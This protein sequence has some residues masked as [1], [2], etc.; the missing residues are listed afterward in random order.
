[1]KRKVIIKNIILILLII[2]LILLITAFIIAPKIILKG[3]KKIHITYQ[4][5]YNDPGYIAKT[6]GQD[7]TTKVRI[8]GKV[9]TDKLGVYQISY[10]VKSNYITTVVKRKVVVIDDVKPI[11]K[12]VG[13]KKIKVCPGNKYKELGYSAIDNYDG[14]I[15]DKVQI[16][17]LEDEIIYTVIDSSFNKSVIKRKLIFI[18]DEAPVISLK[19]DNPYYLIKDRNYNEFGYNIS[20]NCA[21]EINSKVTIS[22]NINNNVVG[23]YNVIYSVQDDFGNE[24][25]AIR[26]VNVYALA[27]QTGSTIYLTF[28]DGPSSITPQVLNILK[29]EGVKATFFVLGGRN[30]FDYLLKRIVDEGHT[31]ALHGTSHNYYSVYASVE[32]YQADINGIRQKVKNVTGIDSKIIRFIGGSSNTVS[33][34]NPGIMSILVKEVQNWGFQ[35]Y[36]WNVSSGD[37]ANISSTQVYN[38]VINGLGSK[39]AYIVLL[40]DY[41]DNH[42]T[43]AVLRSIIKYGKD[44]GYNFNRITEKTPLIHHNVFN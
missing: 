29:E 18:D 12:L 34:F 5:Q 41:E 14:D 39:A 38:N 24:T 35:Y 21:L 33:R 15:T 10:R 20:D 32:A 19:G 31:I 30:E 36:D 26:E 2:V 28:D 8:E 4:E 27:K 40:H 1:M 7:L 9:N 42:K 43:V 11:I 22:N 44:A 3:G 17:E 16:E 25:K 23:T 13:S 37:S 6:I